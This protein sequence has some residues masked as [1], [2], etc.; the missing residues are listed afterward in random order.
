MRL[1]NDGKIDALRRNAN[2][3]KMVLKNSGF[4]E[5]D[6]EREGEHIDQAMVKSVLDI[7]MEI[8]ENSTKYYAK[9]FEESMIKAT[10]MF[11]SHK[12]LNW[13]E[14]E[15]YENYMLKVVQHELLNV[16]AGILAE[17]KHLQVHEAAA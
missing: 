3:E 2:S 17:K 15:S 14:S 11:Y 9:D 7:Y 16:H 4:Y 13:I 1:L 5:I 10:A 8:G 6:K 12:A